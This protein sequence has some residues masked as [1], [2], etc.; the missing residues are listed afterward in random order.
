MSKRTFQPSNLV[1]KRAAWV[2]CTHGDQGRTQ[3][4]ERASAAWPEK[5]ERV[6]RTAFPTERT[7]AGNRRRFCFFT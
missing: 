4:P 7:A 3:D 1:R 6:T 2:P 5:P